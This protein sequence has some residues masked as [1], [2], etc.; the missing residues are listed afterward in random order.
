MSSRSNSPYVIVVIKAGNCSHCQKLSLKWPEIKMQLMQDNL[1]VRVVQVDLPRMQSPIPSGYPTDLK[2]FISWFPMVL[3]VPG[4][5]WDQAM[6]STGSYKF[7][8]VEVFNGKYV[9]GKLQYDG[10][11]NLMDPESF[12]RWVKSVLSHT[13]A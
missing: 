11:Y 7:S 2:R 12:S 3:M 9:G 8:N 5:D 6:H 13:R 1:N 4:A 10:Q